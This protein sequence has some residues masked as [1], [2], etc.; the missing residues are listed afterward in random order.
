MDFPKKG[1][2]IYVTMKS[3]ADLIN[4]EYMVYTENQCTI[5][6]IIEITN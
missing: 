4:D 3:G 1:T 6:Y 5:R 2:E